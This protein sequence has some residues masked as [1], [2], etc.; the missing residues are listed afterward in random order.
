MLSL[1][2]PLNP[3]VNIL[4]LLVS[5]LIDPTLYPSALLLIMRT[6]IS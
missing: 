5:M 3:N 1:I 6:R 2:F 4:T